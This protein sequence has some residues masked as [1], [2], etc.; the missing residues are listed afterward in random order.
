MARRT[1]TSPPPVDR[2]LGFTITGTYSDKVRKANPRLP[3]TWSEDFDCV[4]ELP[5]GVVGEVQNTST[6]ADGRTIF[7]A[8]PTTRFIRHAVVDDQ[9]PRFDALVEDP[10][11]LVRLE[12]LVDV[13][14]YLFEEYAGRPTGPASTSPG[15]QPDTEG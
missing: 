1:F 4:D 13:M 2:D 12:L 14:A 8:G 5:V 3:E 15:G 7:R 6:G 11:R 9:K 10:D